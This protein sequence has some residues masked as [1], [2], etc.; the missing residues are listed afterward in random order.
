MVGTINSPEQEI[1]RKVSQAEAQ[2]FLDE[3][4]K[5]NRMAA[6]EQQAFDNVAYGTTRRHMLATVSHT[7]LIVGGRAHGIA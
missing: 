5:L 2:R 4:A 3:K 6:L 7:A 1:V